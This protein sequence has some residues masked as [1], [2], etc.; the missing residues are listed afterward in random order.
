MSG[1][2]EE[3][4]GKVIFSEE[5]MSNLDELNRSYQIFHQLIEHMQ[6]LHTIDPP[7]ITLLRTQQPGKVPRG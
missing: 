2:D 6:N 1:N 7:P 5:R 4:R 3:S